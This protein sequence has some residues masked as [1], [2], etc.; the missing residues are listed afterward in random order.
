MLTD[1]NWGYHCGCR[2]REVGLSGS[3]YGYLFIPG[4][5]GVLLRQGNSPL[6]FRAGGWA[7]NTYG[8]P[9]CADE[10]V[11]IATVLPAHNWASNSPSMNNDNKMRGT[12]EVVLKQPVIFSKQKRMK[13]LRGSQMLEL[14]NHCQDKLPWRTIGKKHFEQRGTQKLVE[15]VKERAAYRTHVVPLTGNVPQVGQWWVPCQLKP[16]ET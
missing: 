5:G 16:L 1:S 3:L 12:K 6:Q 10:C 2:G 14:T 9:L 11:T 7:G 15:W 4:K 8:S 13:Q